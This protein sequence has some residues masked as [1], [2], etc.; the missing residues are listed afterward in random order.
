VTPHDL[1]ITDVLIVQVIEGATLVGYKPTAVAVFLHWPDPNVDAEIEVTL[2]INGNPIQTIKKVQKA[3]YTIKDT[4]FNRDK[5]IFHLPR[6]SVPNGNHQFTIEARLLNDQFVD[7]DLT[8][9]TESLSKSFVLTKSLTLLYAHQQ[10]VSLSQVHSFHNRAR[11]FLMEVFPLHNVNMAPVVY[12]IDQ[13]EFTFSKILIMEEFRNLYNATPGQYARFIVGLYPDGFYGTGVYGFSYSWARRSVMVGDGSV[14]TNAHEA[15]AHEMGHEFFGEGYWDNIFI[16]TLGEPLPDESF[17]YDSRLRMLRRVKDFNGGLIDLMGRAGGV[18]N[19][20]ISAET[21]NYLVDQYR[22]GSLNTLYNQNKL[23]K[24]F[25]ESARA[26]GF[27]ISGTIDKSDQVN[28]RNMYHFDDIEIEPVSESD[29]WINV[30]GNDNSSVGLFPVAVEFEEDSAEGYFVVNFP[31][32]QNEIQALQILHHDSVIWTSQAS[33]IAP[34]ITIDPPISSQPLKGI[35]TLSWDAS[36]EDSPDLTFSILYSADGGEIWTPLATGLKNPSLEVDFDQLPSGSDC[37]LRVIASDGWNTVT[38][39]TKQSFAVFDDPAELVIESPLEGSVFSTGDEIDLIAYVSDFD[40]PWLDG[41]KIQWDSSLDGDLG[42]GSYMVLT[43]YHRV[44]MKL[45][46]MPPHSIPGPEKN[47]HDHCR[48]IETDRKQSIIRSGIVVEILL[49]LLIAM[50]VL[51]VCSNV[52]TS[53]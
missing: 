8:N 30:V 15:L 1:A 43:I 28:I 53:E 41:E 46:F 19:L 16:E 29:Y 17:T 14:I 49:V 11:G 35:N 39:E 52:K 44:N 42:F 37:L 34:Q 50:I 48:R 33:S 13:N 6:Y 7:S 36:D 18:E 24:L 21:W 4:F 10:N 25:N 2:S 3:T 23:A 51:V 47:R 12:P 20:W 38:A 22:I 26:E 40:S 45:Q 9:N 27:L 5:V 32:D 31:V